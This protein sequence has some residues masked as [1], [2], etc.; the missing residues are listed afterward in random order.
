LPELKWPRHEVIYAPTSSVEFKKAWSCASTASY[1][2]KTQHCIASSFLYDKTM[3]INGIKQFDIIN[4][5]NH[6]RRRKGEKVN[7]SLSRHEGIGE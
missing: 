1:A 3:K 5:R 7:L 4:V 2:F 6:V